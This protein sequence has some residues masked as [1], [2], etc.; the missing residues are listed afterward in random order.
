[1]GYRLGIGEGIKFR[2]RRPL[3]PSFFGQFGTP[4]A[5]YSLRS[6][7]GTDG[8]VVRIRRSIDDAERNFK[9]SEITNGTL[10]AWVNGA[11]NSD[12]LPADFGSG[13]AAAYSLRYV[14]SSYSGNVVRVR[15]SSDDTEQDFTPTEITDGSLLDWVNTDLET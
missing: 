8:N 14:S 1:M 2:V 13:A 7:D 4:A 15:R 10:A 9:P 11:L 3:I 6:L 5:A 12:T